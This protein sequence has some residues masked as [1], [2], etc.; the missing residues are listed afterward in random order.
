MLRCGQPCSQ[1]RAPRSGTS[2]GHCRPRFGVR[3]TGRLGPRSR[4]KFASEAIA[5]R[6]P[7][8]H[9]EHGRLNWDRSGATETRGSPGNGTSWGQFPRRTWLLC[10]CQGWCGTARDCRIR[11][12]LRSDLAP[13]M[14]HLSGNGTLGRT[15]AREEGYS[16]CARPLPSHADVGA[17]RTSTSAARIRV[18]YRFLKSLSRKRSRNHNAIEPVR[19]TVVG[20]CRD[21]WGDLLGRTGGIQ[22]DG[23]GRGLM[24]RLWITARTGTF[25][26]LV[27]ALSMRA[28]VTDSGGRGPSS[29]R[30]SRGRTRA[31]QSRDRSGRACRSGP[32]PGR[33][34]IGSEGRAR[35]PTLVQR[36][37]RHLHEGRRPSRRKPAAPHAGPWR[38]PGETMPL[39]L[40][41]SA[42]PVA[43]FDA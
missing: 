5:H 11:K 8:S 33:T 40:A 41:R 2:W 7:I 6:F 19:G 1:P 24:G 35:C 15:E 23:L 43:A 26:G 29:A 18:I 17:A 22:G 21:V 3:L 32:R 28:I 4:R 9:L 14:S 10:G 36:S 38:G 25:R 37:P 42:R 30:G 12:V 39:P 16:L 34:R 31:E 13:R 27:S 20:R